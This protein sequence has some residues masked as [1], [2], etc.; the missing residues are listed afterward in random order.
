MLCAG[1]RD[2][3]CLKRAHGRPGVRTVFLAGAFSLGSFCA[4]AAAADHDYVLTADKAGNY[5]VSASFINYNRDPLTIV[6]ALAQ[7]AVRQSMAEFGYSASE[8]SALAASCVQ[9]CTQADY[10][11]RVR[12]YYRNQAL[13]TAGAASGPMRVMVDIPAVVARNRPRLRLLA[14]QFDQLSRT[15]AYSPEETVGAMVAFVQ[16]SLP[17]KRPPLREGGRDIL[18]FYPPPR[19]LAAGFGDCDTKSALLAAILTNFPGMRMIGVHIPN[20]YLV[21][22]ARVPRKGDAFIEY[23]GEPFVLIEPSGP[24]WFPPGMIGNTTQTRLNTMTGV[25]IDPLF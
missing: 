3:R 24:A 14:G 13:A 17:Y 18:G 2:A 11:R 7:N 21:G 9:P 12:Q 23:E 10:D 16:T 6:F 25:R 20:H 8:A 4:V 5:R 22:I 19:A 1:A 15:R